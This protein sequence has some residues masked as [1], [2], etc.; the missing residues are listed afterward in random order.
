MREPFARLARP[1]GMRQ[2]RGQLRAAAAAAAVLAMTLIPGIA[3][4]DTG[5]VFDC[6][7]PLPIEEAA[8]SA[9]LVFVGRV[10]ATAF[11]GRSATVEVTEVWRGDVMSPVTV[12]GGQDPANAAED[13]RR[14]E[15]GITYVFVPP[16]L[17]SLRAGVV[18]DSL[19]SSTT[20]WSDEL[21][22]FRP[23][24]VGAPAPVSTQPGPLAFLGDLAMPL[25]SA[26]LLGGGAFLLA[27]LVARRRES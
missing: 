4:A 22:A 21:A 6:A 5:V 12:N 24:D 27:V 8:R 14:F 16:F 23:P 17:E 19:C 18:I 25:I 26:A 1:A 10:T 9:D 11:D 15:V 20:P 7:V 2:P 3:R 13:D